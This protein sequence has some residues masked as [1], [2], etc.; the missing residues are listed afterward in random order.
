M[1]EIYP[2]DCLDPEKKI[3]D[4]S[5]HLGIFDPPFGI[6]EAAF[7]KHYNRKGGNVIPGY[8]EAPTDYAQW[9]LKWMT[10]AKRVLKD[11][12]SMYIIMGNSNLRHVLNAADALG[13]FEINHI[14]WKYQFGVYTKRKYVTSHYHVLFYSKSPKVRHTFN[15]NCRFVQSD[16]DENKGSLL[17]QDLEDVFTI[18][19]VYTPG[20]VKNQNKLPEELI[21]K[22]ILYSSNE[23]DTVCD[24]FMGNFTTAY[25]AL[26][27]GRQVC[28]YEIN[29]EAY[30]HHVQKLK[31]IEPGCDLQTESSLQ[32]FFVN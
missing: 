19:K 31:D 8:T 25:A 32:E 6:G 3:K 18:N 1:I 5:V 9:T 4:G 15:L 10:E 26:R 27:L 13:L 14:I 7:D 30:K 29:P 12:G 22:L 23:G 11:D 28:G 21:K 16:K 20:E 17:Y 24:F 2:E